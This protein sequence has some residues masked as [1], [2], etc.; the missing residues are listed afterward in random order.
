VAP[1]RIF[2]ARSS[3]APRG[4]VS[5]K[6]A[7]ITTAAFT[8][9]RPQASMMLGTV[10]AW[11]AI[12]ARSRRCGMSSTEAKQGTPCTWSCLG[13]TANSLPWNP[14]S[15]MFLMI[16]APIE[17]SRSEAPITATER[18]SNRLLR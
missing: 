8:P 2:T 13:F 14:D 4:P 3:T 1:R 6:P 7:E 10:G 16:T 11:V 18:G 15:T 17:P 9:A 5:E 12:T